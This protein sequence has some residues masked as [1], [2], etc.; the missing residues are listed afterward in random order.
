MTNFKKTTALLWGG[1][2]LASSH[3]FAAGDA[4]GD[5]AGHAEAVGLP[6][7]DPSSFPSQV[8]WLAVVFVV[9]FIFFSKKT[10][11]EISKVI[12][13]RTEHVQN[14]LG[15]A[16]SLKSEA[17]TVHQAYEKIL[18]EARLT[19]M[20]SFSAVE[21]V[22]KERSDAASEDFRKRSA[23]EVTKTEKSVEKAKEKV[24]GEIDSVA[25]QVARDAAEKIIGVQAD[26]K[27]AESVVQSLQGKKKAA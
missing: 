4:H 9:L 13:N 17:E 11:P 8:F 24:L 5:A 21:D 20:S 19:S 2:L 12:E 15:G 14:D 25:A 22:I 7:F 23:K 16:A 26:L 18:E 1:L 10:L 3:A 6:Q 27:H